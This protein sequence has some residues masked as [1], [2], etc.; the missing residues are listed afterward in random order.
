VY[1]S[2]IA[3]FERR[4]LAG[5]R[6]VEGLA[7]AE[8]ERFFQLF[9]ASEDPLVAEQVFSDLRAASIEHLDTI[10]LA[11]VQAEDIAV[12]LDDKAE[13]SGERGRAQRVFWR[14]V[15]GTKKMLVRAAQT[16]RPDLRHAK[17]LVQPFVDQ[18]MNHEYAI[19]GS[20]GAQGPR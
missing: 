4:G 9:V 12:S 19:V 17:R 13:S 2:L 15:L 3:E 10:S 14:A 1:H 18:I 5:F 16:G 6:A 7:G 11:D 8:L 20:H